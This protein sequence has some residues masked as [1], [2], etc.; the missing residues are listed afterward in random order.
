MSTRSGRHLDEL[1]RRSVATTPRSTDLLEEWER[2]RR[3]RAHRGGRGRGLLRARRGGRVGTGREVHQR[4][5]DRRGPQ[6]RLRYPHRAVREGDPGPLPDRRR[7]AGGHEAADED[8]GGP[9]LPHQDSV[10][11][12]HRRAAGA[13][14]RTHQAEAAEQGGRL[15]CVD[16][17]GDLRREDR[18]PYPR[19]GEPD[20]RSDEVR[21]RAEG[22]E[23]LHVGDLSAPTAWC[24]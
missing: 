21:V 12:E 16:A 1:L 10:R 9:H 14:G 20:L 7:A 2:L 22:R 18:A 17:A 4:P 23:G 15:P 5:A 11:P 6:G 3:R 13:P 24:S 19:Q 8:E